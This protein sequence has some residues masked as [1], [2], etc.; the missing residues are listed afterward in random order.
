MSN[1]G[2]T[3][4]EYDSL[5]YKLATLESELKQAQKLLEAPAK[6]PSWWR[7][8]W[9]GVALVALVVLIGAVAW[10]QAPV[11]TFWTGNKYLASIEPIQLGYTAGATD[12]ISLING[13]KDGV[14]MAALFVTKIKDMTAGQFKAIAEKYMKDNPQY[15]HHSMTAITMLVVGLA[16]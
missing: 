2:P 1:P 8:H 10:G 5:I 14:Q 6:R 4:E 7:R 15:R 11:P 3:K 9:S 12:A 13:G 16:K